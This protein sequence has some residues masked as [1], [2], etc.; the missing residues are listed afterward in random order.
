[1]R[2]YKNYIF[3]LYGTLINIYTDEEDPRLWATLAE[4]YSRCGADYDPETLKTAYH[5][6]VR[7]AL[8]ANCKKYGVRYADVK[9]E[10]IFLRLLREA[11]EKHEASLCVSGRVSESVWTAAVANLFRE[12]SIK[13]FSVFPGTRETLA[14]LRARGAKIY[15]LSNAQRVFSLP[16]IEKAGLAGLFDAMYI[17]SDFGMAKPEPA[18]LRALLCGHG[19]DPS[20]CVMVGNDRYSD[21]AIAASCGVPG[22]FL[23]TGN[24]SDAELDAM[25]REGGFAVIRSGNIG[26]LLDQRFQ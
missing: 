22:V 25:E 9:L 4:F 10:K 1:M 13:H 19:L 3:D 11:P 16:E 6:F 5:A 14:A 12:L 2:S 15:L 24:H 18:F 17:S 20:E 26:E 7:E 8:A 23:N 21:M